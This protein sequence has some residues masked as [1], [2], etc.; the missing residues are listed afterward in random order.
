MSAIRLYLKTDKCQS[1]IPIFLIVYNHKEKDEDI[2]LGYTLYKRRHCYE[3][4]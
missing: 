1:L 3:T 2:G 4:H